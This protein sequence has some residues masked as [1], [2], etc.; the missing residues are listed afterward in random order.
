MNLAQFR[1]LYRVFLLRVVDLEMLS[2][3]GDPTR[4]LG[5]IAA[6]FA[7]I[8][9]LFS[10]PLI[11]AS[12]QINEVDLWT[13]EHLLIA[14]T[15]VSAGLFAV[16]S[17][18]AIFPDKRDVLVLAPLPVL[19]G[20]IFVSKLAAMAAALGVLALA[21]NVF[22]G[23]AWP[24]YFSV[25]RSWT[26]IPLAY[27]A[28]WI[29]MLAAASFMLFSV[30]TLQGVA[31][32][33][34]PRQLFLRA[35][36]FLQVACFCLFLA[37]YILEP[38]LEAPEILGSAQAQR[39][40]AWLPSYW[41]LG[42]FHQ[43][44]GY[45]GPLTGVFNSLAQRAW[46]ALA[47][48]AP[49]AA[50]TVLLSY[51]RM[52]RKIVEAPD[53]LPGRR[54]F[55]MPELIA[56]TTDGTITLFSLR[57][58]MRSRHHRVLLSFYF[59]VGLAIILAYLNVFAP[60]PRRIH[61]F[62]PAGNGGSLLAA[63]L[64][65][66]FIAV[67]GMRVIA[68]IPVTLPAHW[69]FRITEL[70]GPGS[71]LRAVR[72]SFLALAV[73]PVALASGLFFVSVWPLHLALEHCAVLVLAGLILVEVSLIAFNKIP[74][75]CSYLPGKGNV[76]FVFWICALFLL[77]VMEAAGEMELLLLKK[78][79]TWITLVSALAV[80]ALAARWSANRAIQSATAIQAKPSLR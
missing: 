44:A 1:I 8:S 57:T 59:G 46:L 80:L 14:T 37:V 58:V 78:H 34:L 72:R 29:T 77:P 71:Y 61:R 32:Q 4:L 48:V 35:S 7:A 41:F 70:R 64:L 40:M 33:L 76:H 51:L 15:M 18:D 47:I 68:A 39:V 24:L 3:D 69:V 27:A 74:F 54:R 19:P 43:L 50:L 63:S 56:G 60:G 73:L 23:L 9:F 28:Y 65:L 22:T 11:L 62:D 5:Q 26:A 42:L 49:G 13:M 75:T 10:A 66:L 55:K 17:W 2:T 30:L 53:I 25:D 52:L 31:S 36:A 16:L 6:L 38:S 79:W 67:A 21:L 20:T 12:G 45:R